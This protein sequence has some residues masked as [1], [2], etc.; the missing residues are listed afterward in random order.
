MGKGNDL[1]DIP[2]PILLG[3]LCCLSLVF[4][5][6]FIIHGLN[7]IDNLKTYEYNKAKKYI[8]PILIT[9]IIF[10]IIEC[11][12]VVITFFVL[13]GKKYM[14]IF[15][16]FF[17]IFIIVSFSINAVCL[18]FFIKDSKKGSGPNYERKIDRLIFEDNNKYKGDRSFKNQAG[19]EDF[20][21]VKL[22]LHILLFCF[23]IVA[24]SKK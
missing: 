3:V 12:S 23:A 17:C 18:H 1:E 16:V 9:N 24:E 15:K 22:V 20:T 6:F 2:L 21:Y 7:F 11:I 13:I 10:S 19:S 4:N 8:L 5:T 14:G